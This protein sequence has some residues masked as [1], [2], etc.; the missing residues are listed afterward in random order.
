LIKNILFDFDGVICESVDIKTE[1][2][3]EM[4]ISSGED[5]AQKVKFHHLKNGGMSRYDKFKYYEEVFLEKSITTERMNTLSTQFSK[6]V[7]EKVIDAPF[8]EGALE[9]LEKNAKRYKCFIISAT[10]IDEMREIA[11]AKKIDKY[12]KEIFGSPTNKIEWGKYILNTYNLKTQE[13]VFVGDALSDFN[14]A[15]KN[16]IH[17]LL[18]QTKDN[19]ELFSNEVSSISNL[20]SLI[21][22]LNTYE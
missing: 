11:K 3:Y 14:A 17:F 8:V 6:L 7:K 2:F 21:K 1:A 19:K 15:K 4:Y 16:N 10:P 20:T 22:I 18:R 5:I 9:F 12:F 13:T